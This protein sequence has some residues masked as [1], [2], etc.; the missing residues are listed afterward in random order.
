MRFAFV[1][2]EDPS[3]PRG[4]L[5]PETLFSDKQKQLDGAEMAFLNLMRAL[6][7]RGHTCA[8]C[9]G[10][11]GERLFFVPHFSLNTEPINRVPPADA[12]LV[13]DEPS[14]L[15]KI[16][17][18]GGKRICCVSRTDLDKSWAEHEEYVD[19]FVSPSPAHRQHLLESTGV[20][21]SRAIWLPSPINLAAY[22]KKAE[23]HKLPGSMIW[24]SSPDRG[25]DRLLEMMPEIRRRVPEATL[26]IFHPVERWCAWKIAEAGADSPAGKQAEYILALLEELRG[27]DPGAVQLIGRVPNARLPRELLATYIA[28]YPCELPVTGGFSHSMLEACAAWTL[29]IVSTAGGLDECFDDAACVIRKSPSEDK[30]VW[31]DTI[32]RTLVNRNWHAEMTEYARRFATCFDFENVAIWWENAMRG[33]PLPS[34]VKEFTSAPREPRQ[35]Y[36]VH[37]QGE[38]ETLRVALIMGKQGASIHG[39]FDMNLIYEAGQALTGTGLNFF[40]LAWGLAERGCAV[41]VFCD[42]DK[43]ARDVPRLAGANVYPVD[44]A[45][46]DDYDAYLTFNEPDLMRM[47]PAERL[48]ICVM[49]LNG[50]ELAHPSYDKYIDLYSVPSHTLARH[51]HRGSLEA[52]PSYQI[53]PSK[54]HVIPLSVNHEFYDQIVKR[55]PHSIVYS[56]SPDRGLHHLLEFFPEIRARVPDA[57]L[58]IFYRFDPWYQTAIK[59]PKSPLYPAVLS[60][61]RSLEK[62]GRNGENG[63]T[64]VGPV[65][66][67][68]LARELLGTRVFAYTCDPVSFTEGFSGAIMDACAAGCVPIISQVDAL[69]EVYGG[70]AYVIPG[71]PAEHRREWIDTIVAAMTDDGF[72][73]QLRLPARAFTLG[74][75]RQKI[76][77]QYEQLIRQN[78][79][80]RGPRS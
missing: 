74:F 37:A 26:G 69:P 51:L 42:T 57:T 28:P 6:A 9:T 71:R 4:R 67:R 60:I 29:P 11:N 44:M 5:V 36:A 31:I 63:V 49:Y 8:I 40:N 22:S 41:D 24:S 32:V 46:G 27:K 18:R 25:L 16:E 80:Q 75:T 33:E 64:L 17:P 59:M 52:P 50:F 30:N 72:A 43:I 65:P 38:D 15:E 45:I 13:L 7:M 53:S 62:L 61:G 76:A 68:T 48:R 21:P 34:T 70:A 66:N 10:R 39:A 2:P 54:I 79:K 23:V 56:S 3:D 73:D 20:D 47:V 19:L 55:E 14:I 58:K 77:A 35:Q 12:Y 1:F 78:L